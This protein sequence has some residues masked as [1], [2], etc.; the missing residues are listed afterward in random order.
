MAVGQKYRSLV[1]GTDTRTSGDAIKYSFVSGA[2]TAGARCC[3][4]GTLPTP[5]LAMAAANFSAGVMITASHNPPEYNGIKL[6]NPDGSAFDPV[7]QNEIE[8][9]ISDDRLAAVTWSGMSR[10]AI[11][12]DAVNAHIG[13][14]LGIVTGRVNLKVVLDCGCGAASVI[15]PE[16]LRKMGCEVVTMNCY[17]TGFFPR[18]AEP[19]EANL[20]DLARAVKELEADLGIAHDGDADRMMAVDDKGRFIP[21]DKLLLLFGREEAAKKVVTTIDASMLIEE[22][23][24]EVVRTPVGDTFVSDELKRGGDFGGEPS[25]SWVFPG[26]S[27]CPDGVFAAA[28]LAAI[29]AEN[30]VSGLV[31]GIPRYPIKRGSVPSA[32]IDLNEMAERLLELGPESVNDI[33]GTRLNFSDGWLL[34]RPSGTEPKIRITAEAKTSGRLEKLYREGIG[35]IEGSAK[36][37]LKN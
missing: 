21:G 6:I 20:A 9:M 24:F 29:A 15:S 35:A 26:N 2:L 19:T 33:D 37:A 11:L 4:A 25:G 1:V 10:A 27:L 30:K 32:G 3:D 13:H 5:T 18:D 17:P 28:R 14:I 16:M 36:R 7:Q 12:T 31:D 34:V 22:S 23:G 8:E